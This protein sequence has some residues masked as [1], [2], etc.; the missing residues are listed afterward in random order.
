MYDTIIIG[1]RCAGSPTAMLL[2]QKG[3]S[4]LVLDRDSFP[5]DTVSTHIIKYPGVNQL[6]KW[7]LLDDVVATG[8]PPLRQVR[9]HN[10]DFLLSGTAPPKDGIS[11][12]APRRTE[13]DGI[14]VEAAVEAGAEVREE[15]VVWKLLT[16]GERVV[17][18]EGQPK[19]GESVTERARIVIG[20]DGKNPLVARTIDPP[21]YE[22][23]TPT[24]FYYYSYWPDLPD[25][26]LEFHWRH[27]QFVL[28]IPTNDGL[29]C[30]VAGRPMEYYR[31]FSADVE[32]NYH[33]TIAI[34]PVL[35]DAIGKLHPVEPYV[36]MAVPHYFRR[37]YGSG[38]ALVGD[39]GLCMDPLQG[40]GIS[41]AFCDAELL[42]AAIDAG[43]A[44]RQ[45][46]EVALAEYERDRNARKEGYYDRNW[47]ASLM[48]GWDD[49]A[50][51]RLRAALRDNPG[52]ADRWAGTIAFSVDYDEFY[53]SP[54]VKDSMASAV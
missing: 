10:G 19:G 6:E 22:E 39:S 50:I 51:L 24:A 16:E 1:A 48:E 17:G 53:S 49:P 13:L 33:E 3:Y 41:D 38:W 26:G 43:F 18:I 28:S 29:T 11:M 20:A 36:G 46:L 52:E 14:L 15:F 12:I 25:R 40:H 47:K 9:S 27:H 21:T 23:H 44:G 45:P 54:F 2:A 37:P 35:A 5:S 34:V 4:V 42:A 31:E 8:C 32:R 30:L 7:G